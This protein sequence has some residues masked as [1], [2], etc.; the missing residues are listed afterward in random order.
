MLFKNEQ[1]LLSLHKNQF[2][3]FNKYH[4]QKEVVYFIQTSILKSKQKNLIIGKLFILEKERLKEKV[5]I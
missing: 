5:Q 2:F 4:T 1:T 3:K